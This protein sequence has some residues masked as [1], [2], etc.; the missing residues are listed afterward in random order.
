[1]LT[2][3]LAINKLGTL[4]QSGQGHRPLY[5]TPPGVWSN[6]L[7]YYEETDALHWA[8]KGCKRKWTTNLLFRLGQAPS[9]PFIQKVSK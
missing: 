7:L 2:H 1:M 4:Y 3:Y 8:S 9:G 5:V 6:I